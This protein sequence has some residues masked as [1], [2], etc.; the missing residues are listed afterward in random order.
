MKT[1]MYEMDTLDLW[2]ELHPVDRDY[3]HYPDAMYFRTDYFLM[4]KGDTYKVN[5]FRRG[6]T[7]ISD[8]SPFY[9]E[10][11]LNNKRKNTVWRLTEGML[12]NTGLVE[13]LKG[14]IISYREENDKLKN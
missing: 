10:N 6:V 8:H 12:N 3:T 13:E 1:L 11:N 5:E 14:E 9:L 2:R 7:D 4:N